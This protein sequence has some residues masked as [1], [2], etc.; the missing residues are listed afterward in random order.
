MGY[1]SPAGSRFTLLIP[2]RNRPDHTLELVRYVR[3]ELGWRMPIVI[4][5]Q[6]D[7][8]GE[9]LSALLS[10]YVDVE[11]FADHSRGANRG[12]NQ[13]A[14][15]ARSEWLLLIDDDVRPEKGYLQSLTSFIDANPWVDAVQCATEQR[16]AW[17]EYMS[18]T[19]VRRENDSCRRTYPSDWSGVQWFTSSPWASHEALAIG[20]GAGNLAVTREAYFN[21]GGFDERMRGP[22]EDREFGL[23]LWW[24]GYRCCLC[25][26]A[27]AFHLREPRGGR[28]EWAA[29]FRR[30]LEPE[31]APSWIYFHLK[32]FPGRPSAELVIHYLLKYSARPWKAP[33]K[34][35]RL[36]RSFREAKRLMKAGPV[37]CSAPVPRSARHQTVAV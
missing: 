17:Q 23:R 9:K 15:R 33:I 7:D 36:W 20:V 12:R 31:P 35:I 16:Q 4:A 11:H 34:Y 37:Y 21:V 13:A 10:G 1:S 32:W 18:G 25:S 24:L 19:W 22:G 6:S 26:E 8:A 5:D 3:E 14:S 2:T 29:G 27:V 30:I 28:R